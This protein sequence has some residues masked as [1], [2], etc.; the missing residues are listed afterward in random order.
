MTGDLFSTGFAWGEDDLSQTAAT[1]AATAPIDP[2]T[3]QKVEKSDLSSGPVADVA[4]VAERESDRLIARLSQPIVAKPATV[5]ATPET[6]ENRGVQAS[7]GVSVAG[8]ATVAEWQAGV[9][10][11]CA[12]DA[13]GKIHDLQRD[14]VRLLRDWG[15]DLARLGWSTLDVW[16]SNQCLEHRRVDRDGLIQGVRGGAV[17]AIDCDTATIAWGEDQVTYYRKLRA[18]GG[19]PVWRVD[20]GVSRWEGSRGC[21]LTRLPPNHPASQP[22]LGESESH[23]L[24]EYQ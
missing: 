5:P 19:V 8:V 23:Q 12:M 1:P 2:A 17:V 7:S 21:A 3:S 22:A 14:A 11:L 4:S 13:K 24:R 9:E 15:A 10:A 16:A 18:A 20:A 6:A